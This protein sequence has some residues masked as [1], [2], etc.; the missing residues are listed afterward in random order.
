M[1]GLLHRQGE[2]TLQERCTRGNI[3]KN[4]QN[5]SQAFSNLSEQIWK[6]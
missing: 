3:I 2:E 6:L 5:G 1:V 4:I